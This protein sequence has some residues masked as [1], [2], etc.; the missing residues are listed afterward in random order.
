MSVYNLMSVFRH[1]L[2][3]QG[4]HLTLSALHHRLRC[5]CIL[6][7]NPGKLVN[8]T[9]MAFGVSGGALYQLLCTWHMA[10]QRHQGVKAV[11]SIMH[12]A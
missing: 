7:G 4:V 8:K 9:A 5:G 12:S 1:A 6:D 3:R 2:M 11:A 10:V